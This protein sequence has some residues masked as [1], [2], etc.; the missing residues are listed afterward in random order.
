MQ[1]STFAMATT[2]T[3]DPLSKDY[4]WRPKAI[5]CNQIRKMLLLTVNS[6]SEVL[7]FWTVISAQYHHVLISAA[8]RCNNTLSFSKFTQKYPH[9]GSYLWFYHADTIAQQISFLCLKHSNLL[10][11]TTSHGGKGGKTG[12]QGKKQICLT[13]VF[14]DV[15]WFED[16]TAVVMKSCI[17]CDILLCRPLKVNRYFGGTWCLYLQGQRIIQARN[18]HEA[19]SKQKLCFRQ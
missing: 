10:R 14:W 17:W 1:M 6:C 12:I 3:V 5:K 13:L 4:T 11:Q 16:I 2:N 15:M 9:T 8:E 18:L 7:T 19:S